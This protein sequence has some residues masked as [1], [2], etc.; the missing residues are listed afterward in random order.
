MHDELM[1]RALELVSECPCADGCPSCVGPGGEN[2]YG[3][4]QEALEILK[5]LTSA[6]S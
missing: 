4:K 6:F 5:E 1:A 3:G 2:G